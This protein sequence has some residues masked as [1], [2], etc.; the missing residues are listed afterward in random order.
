MT[1][2]QT[3]ALPI[4]FTGTQVEASLSLPGAVADGAA[5]KEQRRDVVPGDLPFDAPRMLEAS[6]AARYPA[7]DD[8]LFGGVE[9]RF[10]PGGISPLL[11][12][13]RR[14]LSPGLPAMMTSPD[15]PPRRI[16]AGVLRSSPPFCFFSP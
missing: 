7:S 12:S 6:G 14:R 1:G 16:P 9:P 10:F 13:S 5:K 4:S 11:R 3:C 8:V 15:S 2:V